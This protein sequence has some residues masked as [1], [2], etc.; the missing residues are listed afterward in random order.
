MMKTGLMKQST[1]SLDVLLVLAAWSRLVNSSSIVL[2]L[3]SLM[4]LLSNSSRT[5]VIAQ[6]FCGNF[7]P[8]GIFVTPAKVDSR[9]SERPD[10]C[11]R[12]PTAP[13]KLI[14]VCIPTIHLIMSENYLGYA[15]CT[16]TAT[17]YSCWLLVKMAF[18]WPR[19][20]VSRFA[21]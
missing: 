16:S 12:V 11:I 2:I 10:P 19:S 3:L 20:L 15:H 6:T 9:T 5:S 18:F 8:D 4:V 13:A 17:L 21:S 14:N 1:H 7:L